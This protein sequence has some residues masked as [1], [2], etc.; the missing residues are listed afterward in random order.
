M[1]SFASALL[2]VLVWLVGMA[3]LTDADERATEIQRAQVKQ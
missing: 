3:L 2:I 1:R